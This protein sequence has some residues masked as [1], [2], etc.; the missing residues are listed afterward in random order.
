MIE[1]TEEELK[2]QIMHLATMFT[3]MELKQKKHH[4]TIINFLRDYEK[5]L[6][7]LEEYVILH[8]KKLDRL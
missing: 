4:T 7:K 5:R 1:L 6:D 2:V 3:D 8:E